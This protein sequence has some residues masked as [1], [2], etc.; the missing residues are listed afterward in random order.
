MSPSKAFATFSECSKK[1]E[2]GSAR[3]PDLPGNYSSLRLKRRIW[4]DK[5]GLT[6]TNFMLRCKRSMAGSRGKNITFEFPLNG[7]ERLMPFNR[8]A[9]ERI[10]S[11]VVAHFGFLNSSGFLLDC[12]ST[13]IFTPDLQMQKESIMSYLGQLGSLGEAPPTWQP[14]TGLARHVTLFNHIGVGSS[15]ET[16][17]IALSNLAVRGVSLSTICGR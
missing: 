5:R 13:A 16:G 15:K 10:D 6:A 17:E 9:I 11:I 12:Y 7:F 4:A 14:P 1:Y 3:P 2:G 8:F